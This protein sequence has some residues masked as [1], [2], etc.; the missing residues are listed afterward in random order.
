M[1]TIEV[2]QQ[3][4]KPARLRAPT[5]QVNRALP[6]AVRSRS[7]S[8][9]R[10]RKARFFYATQVTVAP[11]TLVVFV[12]DPDLVDPVYCRYLASALRRRLPFPEVPIR[13][14]FRPRRPSQEE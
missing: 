2:P 10:G 6:D 11:P 9:S 13:L 5:A 1:P 12:N 14:V 4:F 3:L 8:P 7:P